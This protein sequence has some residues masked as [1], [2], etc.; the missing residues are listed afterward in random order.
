ML[1]IQVT[2]MM[3][4][5][6]REEFLSRVA[7]CGIQ[8]A[9]RREKGCLQYDYFRSVDDPDLLLLLE[10]W[11]DAESQ[12]LHMEQP[13]MKELATIKDHCV[14]QVSLERFSL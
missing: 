12:R 13:H 14:A 8:S 5:G 11:T 4:P 1:G 3:K 9:V 6:M 10:R 2:Y 7:A